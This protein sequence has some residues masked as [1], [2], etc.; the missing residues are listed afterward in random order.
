MK[1]QSADTITTLLLEQRVSRHG[2][3][4]YY[5]WF[6]QILFNQ[7]K[8]FLSDLFK[9]VE[10]LLGFHRVNT[11]AYHPQ[12]DGLVRRFNKILIEMLAKTN[13]GGQ[14]WNCHF[15]YMLFAYRAA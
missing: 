12:M 14:E 8:A 10:K 11:T 1:N 3:P 13:E 2:V 7:R 15:P 9:E 6:H 5:L 4:P